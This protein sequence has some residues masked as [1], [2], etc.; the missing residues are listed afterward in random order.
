MKFVLNDNAKRFS[1]FPGDGFLNLIFVPMLESASH[2][3]AA[4][5]VA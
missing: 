2:V 4:F 1:Q 5:P 3:V